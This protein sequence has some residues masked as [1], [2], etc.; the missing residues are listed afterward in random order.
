MNDK[1]KL[2][3]VTD[4]YLDFLREVKPKIPMNKDNGKNRPFVGIVLS[5]NG[6]KYIAPLSSKKGKGQSDFKVKIG[7]EQKATV[8]FAYM[9]P[10]VNSALVDIDYTK[11]FQLDF[12]YTALLINEDLYINQHKDRIHEIATKTYTN[13]VTKRFGFENF[14]RDFAKLE[15]RSKSYIME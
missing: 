13:T 7:N 14:C 1:L 3:R 15:D 9:F 2:Y 12:K 4:H 8:R 6:M 11:E 5:I 10:L